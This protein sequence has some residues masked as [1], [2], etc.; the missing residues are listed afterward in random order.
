M[1]LGRRAVLAEVLRGLGDAPKK[2]ACAGPPA[3]C[4]VLARAGHTVLAWGL[5]VRRLA[6]ARRRSQKG[7]TWAIVRAQGGAL[8]V[9]DGELDAVVYAGALPANAEAIVAEWE[10]V[11]RDGGRVVIASSV[12]PGLWARLR[13][14]LGGVRLRPLAPQDYT[15]LMLL[16]GFT[17]V[18]QVWPRRSIVITAA[19]VRKIPG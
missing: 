4:L 17:D 2:V 7:G 9:R 8:P 16:G 10:R 18:R 12:K 19:R 6:S 14:R 5:Q 1:I 13:A 15:R 3:L 11:V